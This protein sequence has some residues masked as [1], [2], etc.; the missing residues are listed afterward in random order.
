VFRFPLFVSLVPL[1]PQVTGSYQQSRRSLFN[2]Q[3]IRGR[4]GV[5]WQRSVHEATQASLGTS[6]DVDAE[7]FSPF[8]HSGLAKHRDHI[9][10]TPAAEVR[11][12]AALGSAVQSQRIGSSTF[13][14]FP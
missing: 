8:R 3:N 4:A 11:L 1:L 2:L 7:P 14:P 6:A 9:D 10:T 13:T 12:P 5:E